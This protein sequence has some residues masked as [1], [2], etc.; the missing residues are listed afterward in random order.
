MGTREV[1]AYR[2]CVHCN[3]PADGIDYKHKPGCVGEKTPKKPDPWLVH[4][5][6][7]KLIKKIYA[8]HEGNV[9]EP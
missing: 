6:R 1:F 4:P 5:S 8:D 3:G 7:L 2:R 9:N